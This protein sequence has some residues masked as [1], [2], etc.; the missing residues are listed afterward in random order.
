MLGVPI[1][2]CCCHISN[3]QK[4]KHPRKGAGLFYLHCGVAI[5]VK[6]QSQ[7]TIRMTGEDQ[8]PGP[9]VP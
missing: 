3:T 7:I 9:L 8:G 6:R 2:Y 1:A 4:A 5:R